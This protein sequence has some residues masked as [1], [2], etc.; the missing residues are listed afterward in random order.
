MVRPTPASSA[1]PRQS[2][3]LREWNGLPSISDVPPS[4][5]QTCSTEDTLS[6]EQSPLGFLWVNCFSKGLLS[7]DLVLITPLLEIIFTG[8]KNEM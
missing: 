5:A 6:G 1:P 8:Y 3:L 7:Q 4:V 2:S